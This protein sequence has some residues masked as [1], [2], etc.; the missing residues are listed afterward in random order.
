MAR[1]LSLAEIFQ[2]G[3][4]WEGKVL[5]PAVKLDAFGA[6]AK[7]ARTV[8]DVSRRLR[9]DRKATEILMNALA[10]IGLLRKSGEQTFCQGTPNSSKEDC[11]MKKV[12]VMT[13]IA[14]AAIAL[15]AVPMSSWAGGEVEGKVTFS[16]KPPAPKEF[17]FSPP[18]HDDIGT[19]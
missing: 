6:L 13:A 14:I 15:L 7:G 12:G 19:A 2:L 5:L 9:T 11:V 3:Y 17:L 10:S 1:T 4:Y 16:G 18:A 8:A